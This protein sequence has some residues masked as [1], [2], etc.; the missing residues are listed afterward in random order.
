MRRPAYKNAGTAA[1][2]ALS[3]L[4]LGCKKPL[5]GP[6]DAEPHAVDPQDVT[7]AENASTGREPHADA[8]PEVAAHERVTRKKRTQEEI[9]EEAGEHVRSAIA[10]AKQKKPDCEKV[11]SLLD[12]SF[13][14]VSPEVD[15]EDRAAFAN[16][17]QCAKKEQRW[18]LLRAVANAIIQGEPAQK[19]TYL[20]PRA[21]LGLGQYDIAARL[22]SAALR[23]WPKEGEAYTTGAL[24]STRIEDWEA[25][26]K[27]ADQALLVQR[28]RGVSDEISAQAHMFKGLA[29]LHQGKLEESS[30][31]FDVA[32][33]IKPSELVTQLRERN[34]VV[35]STGLLVEADLPSEVPLGI[36]PFFVKNLPYTGGLVTLRLST[37]SD[38]PVTAR[39]ELSL[40][41]VSDPI[42]KSVTVSRGRR[43]TMHLT[44]P[45]RADLKLDTLKEPVK[46]DLKLKV[47]GND[48]Q[49]IY[50]ET[51]NALVLPKDDLPTALELHEMD[52]RPTPELV[53]A[54]IT[55]TAKPVASLL[56]AAKK[57]AGGE[58]GGKDAPTL[59]QVKAIWDE[60]RDRGFAFVR[61]PSLDSEV[62]HFYTTNL[63]SE[64]LE[65]KAGQALEGSLLLASLLEAVGLDVLI[66]HVPGHVFVGWMPTK[67]DRAA[68]EAMSA[69]V[70][71]PV[72]TAFFL[73]TTMVGEGPADAAVLRGAAQ[74]VDAVTKKVFDDGRATLLR[75]PALRKLGIVPPAE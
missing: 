71:S 54:W 21:L 34:D 56:E 74:L 65:D 17:A 69:A 41:G 36:Y 15:A 4:L 60:L 6:A 49:V 59:P 27:E 70:P 61:D 44:P 53:A 64:T 26:N 24:A 32:K 73:E 72:G 63:P 37:T 68:S 5:P 23:S 2:V 18:R 66:V 40:D 45:L 33:R 31:E 9:V 30:K 47:T 42:G 57:R 38:K 39:V 12:V 25:C 28:Q 50:E 22:S 75:L 11:A 58:L 10:E 52:E 46:H 16:I 43:E 55:P 51:R 7:P 29:L 3:L 67:A 8:A 13:M 19:T 1:G 14:I 62:P 20:L 48:G 35:K